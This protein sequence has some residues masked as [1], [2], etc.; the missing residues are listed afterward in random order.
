[1][2]SASCLEHS[3]SSPDRVRPVRRFPLPRQASHRR[4]A[5]VDG[6]GRAAVPAD[7]GAAEPRG[8]LRRI[9]GALLRASEAYAVL[10]RNHPM[11]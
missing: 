8:R 11:K 10:A 2:N 4:Q 7:D 6:D 1:M 3:T 9:A 5:S